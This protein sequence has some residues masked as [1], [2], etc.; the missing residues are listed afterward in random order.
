MPDAVGQGD[1]ALAREALEGA[2]AR[3]DERIAKVKI[4]NAEILRILVGSGMCAHNVLLNPRLDKPILGTVFLENDEA[5]ECLSAEQQNAAKLASVETLRELF[6]GEE[7]FDV[8]LWW[9]SFERI[10]RDFRGSYDEYLLSL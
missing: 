8:E 6:P 1:G 9:D 3:Q 5:L 2:F 10:E 7:I 4:A